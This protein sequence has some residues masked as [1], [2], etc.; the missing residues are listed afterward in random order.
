MDQK[1]AALVLGLEADY[2]RE[3][4]QD[5]YDQAIW[6]VK[7]WV[8]RTTVVPTLMESRIKRL[9]QTH[10]AFLAL[11]GTTQGM[12]QAKLST[13]LS[14]ENAIQFLE[15]YEQLGVQI[16][17][18]LSAATSVPSVNHALQGLNALQ[19]SYH[20]A[21]GNTFQKEDLVRL[22]IDAEVK[23]GQQADTGVLLRGMRQVDE[24]EGWFNIGQLKEWQSHKAFAAVVDMWLN[25]VYR[26]LKYLELRRH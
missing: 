12:P 16:R 21:I 11:E 2:D 23:I 20:L 18:A 26:V 19:N 17:A 13:E 10:E 8:F 1:Q 15:D 22:N 7:N 3:D 9:T 25:E 14:F 6:E 24:V 5:A 4:V